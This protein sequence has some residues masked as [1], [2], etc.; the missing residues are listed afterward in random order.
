MLGRMRT[1]AVEQLLAG[2]HAVW[3]ALH[4]AAEDGPGKV[5]GMASGSQKYDVVTSHRMLGR[6]M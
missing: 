5:E 4:A 6:L 2:L 1:G 3:T